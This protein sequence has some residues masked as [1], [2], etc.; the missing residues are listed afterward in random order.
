MIPTWLTRLIRALGVAADLCLLGAGVVALT[1]PPASIASTT[2]RPWIASTW[3][4]LLAVGA[5]VALAGNATQ[6]VR[7]QIAGVV[8]TAGGMAVW[9]VAA[10][11]QPTANLASF[12]VACGFAAAG[13]AQGWRVMG[14][15][16]GIELRRLPRAQHRDRPWIR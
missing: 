5:L 8:A 14:L 11:T 12:G 1:S 4:A 2:E 16:A 13:Y 9:A 6:H 7:V 3:A 10:V 15:L